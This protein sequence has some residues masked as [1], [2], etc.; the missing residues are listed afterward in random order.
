MANSPNIAG[1]GTGIACLAPKL[2]LKMLGEHQVPKSVK[3]F[4]V[5]HEQQEFRRPPS[6][7]KEAWTSKI[8]CLLSIG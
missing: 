3:L 4:A 5:F 1:F 2:T 8:I 7:D 6:D